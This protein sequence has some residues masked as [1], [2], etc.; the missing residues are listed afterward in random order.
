[1]R[2]WTW[3]DHGSVLYIIENPNIEVDDLLTSIQEVASSEK[4]AQKGIYNLQGQKLNALPK[5]GV[6]IV[7]G[8]KKVIRK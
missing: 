6:V 7:D 8:K 5:E 1:V 2:N 3:S 4:V